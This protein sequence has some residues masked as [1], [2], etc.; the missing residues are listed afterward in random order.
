MEAMLSFVVYAA[1]MLKVLSNRVS[2][3]VVIGKITP[4]KIRLK[5]QKCVATT[6]CST[7]YFLFL[8]K[9]GLE[10]NCKD[11]YQQKD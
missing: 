5:D 4:S 11:R 3:T 10:Q 6:T 7:K 9:Q 1:E 8:K 2:S